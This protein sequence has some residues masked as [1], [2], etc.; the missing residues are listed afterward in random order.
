M[1]IVITPEEEFE[2]RQRDFGLIAPGRMFSCYNNRKTRTYIAVE[3]KGDRTWR[4]VE[5]DLLN[6]ERIAR[7]G[8][9]MLDGWMTRRENSTDEALYV[10]DLHFDQMNS[11]H[12]MNIKMSE[13]ANERMRA[14]PRLTRDEYLATMNGE[15]H[16]V[17]RSISNDP[18]SWEDC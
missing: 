15:R 10:S 7:N 6:R 3:F 12:V 13:A 14:L 1:M 8:H 4:V 5:L 17:H 2:N 18:G 9:N 16:D 11:L